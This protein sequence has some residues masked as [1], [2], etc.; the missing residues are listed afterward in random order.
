M[1]VVPLDRPVTVLGTAG[2]AKAPPRT[3]PPQLPPR[4]PRPPATGEQPPAPDEGPAPKAQPIPR[5]K[6]KD[7]YI[8]M[9]SEQIEKE[10]AAAR[11]Q[12][13]L[14]AA[15][16]Q[17]RPPAQ[18]QQWGQFDPK[19]QQQVTQ[20]VGAVSQAATAGGGGMSQGQSMALQGLAAG[21][22][23]GAVVGAAVGAVEDMKKEFR[24]AAELAKNMAVAIGSADTERF[25]RGLIDM[26]EK[27][28]YVGK[29][30]GWLAG[31]VL[32]VSSAI[33][34]TSRRLS[35]YDAGLA[36]QQAELEVRS[37][38]R[39]LD[40]AQ[41]I[42][43]QLERATQARADFD[44]KIQ[45]AI[46]RLLPIIATG[47]SRILE[48]VNRVEET[49]RTM[50]E[51]LGQGVEMIGEIP[52]IGGAAQDIITAIRRILEQQLGIMLGNQNQNNDTNQVFV[53][54][55]LSA[56]ATDAQA[57]QEQ[58]QQWLQQNQNPNAPIFPAF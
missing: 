9:A 29:A 44:A 22:P 48:T 53:Q 23:I 6:A 43:P 4:P 15:R 57:M 5:V 2:E 8:Q 19:T 28:P 14:Q 21:G 1:P 56:S 35:I 11:E 50:A 12:R 51:M 32:D 58:M 54:E 25:E 26:G 34:Q 18:Q 55:L 40:R 33:D 41:R 24:E 27:I 47:I 31:S 20:K 45:D 42:G 46:D 30:L 52:L 38:Y 10:E 16:D 39:D 3:T 49:A 37:I 36:R 13:K 7:P 17:L